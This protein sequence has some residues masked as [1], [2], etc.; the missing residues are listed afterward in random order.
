MIAPFRVKGGVYIFYSPGYNSLKLSN[1]FLKNKAPTTA[2]IALTEQV[3]FITIGV[4]IPLYS[5][6]RQLPAHGNRVLKE[7]RGP[8]KQ[9][10]HERRNRTVQVHMRENIRQP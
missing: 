8:D 1:F 7:L 10:A 5:G 4:L 6:L 3:L 9:N 2:S